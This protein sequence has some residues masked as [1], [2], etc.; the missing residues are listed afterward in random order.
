MKECITKIQPYC[1]NIK[2]QCRG[3]YDISN[4]HL[5]QTKEMQMSGV[6]VENFEGRFGEIKPLHLTKK[7][8]DK[9]TAENCFFT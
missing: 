2:T 7:N 5:A 4:H 9:N 6:Q 3:S 8:V 1:E